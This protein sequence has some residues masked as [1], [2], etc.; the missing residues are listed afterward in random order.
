MWHV[1]S[2][3]ILAKRKDSLFSFESWGLNGLRGQKGY[4]LMEALIALALFLLIIVPFIGLF[5][6]ATKFNK[7]KEML[8]ASFILEQETA[9]IQNNPEEIYTSKTRNISGKN[10]T[11]K[12]ATRGE[13]LKTIKLSAI[14]NG[15]SVDEVEFYVYA[16]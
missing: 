3:S 12:A 1:L 15:K 8:T 16:P 10:W 14:R 9:I 4:T 13:G 7:G 2:K 5:G 6:N 11:V